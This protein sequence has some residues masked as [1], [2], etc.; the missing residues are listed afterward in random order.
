L[1]PGCD[2]LQAGSAAGNRLVE[3]AADRVFSGGKVFGFVK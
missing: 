1:E 3:P 2:L